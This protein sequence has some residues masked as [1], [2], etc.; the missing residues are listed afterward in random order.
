H[1]T[2]MA[3]AAFAPHAN[4][5]EAHGAAS[6][7]QTDLA[8]AIGGITFLILILALVASIFD[9]KFAVLAARETMLLR[10]SEEQLQKLYR[11]TPLPLHVI[12][13]DGRI[14]KVSD[15]WLHLLGYTF[16]EVSGRRLTD[17][18]TAHS[19]REYD[20]MVWPSLQRGEEVR[21]VELQFVRKS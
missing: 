7:A 13:L 9:R 18:T 15:A 17:L 8:L 6:L 16:E 14:E 3:A 5:A 20:G 4:A 19:K 11:E 12:G 2:G 1:Y 10:E 21:E